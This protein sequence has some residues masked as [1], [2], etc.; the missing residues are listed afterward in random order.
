MQNLQIYREGTSTK[1]FL[2]SAAAGLSVLLFVTIRWYLW[3][4]AEQ[5]SPNP[6]TGFRPSFAFFMG[7]MYAIPTIVGVFVVSA[8]I[9]AIV[10]FIPRRRE[11]SSTQV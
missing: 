4:S 6:R 9:F 8:V 11:S 2:L 3:L 10:E 1:A 5:A 7:L